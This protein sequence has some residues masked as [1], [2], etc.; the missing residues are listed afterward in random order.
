MEIDKIIF[1]LKWSD[2][3]V[4]NGVKTSFNDMGQSIEYDWCYK[5][6]TEEWVEITHRLVTKQGT[7]SNPSIIRI[8]KPE[9]PN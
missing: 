2:G 5:F 7:I 3:D 4:G 9:G 1:D 6:G 8:N